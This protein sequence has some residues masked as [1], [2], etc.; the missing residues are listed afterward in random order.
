[1][2]KLQV[3]PVLAAAAIFL[4]LSPHFAR[5][6]DQWAMSQAN[7]AHT[8]YVPVTL[9]PNKFALRWKR[10]IDCGWRPVTV[11]G[12]RVF[13]TGQNLHALDA[14][15]GADV[16][17]AA[18]SDFIASYPG[19]ADGKV[20]IETANIA[21][22][23]AAHLLSYDAATGAPVFESG[24]GEIGGIDTPT[25]FKDN[26]YMDDL[27]SRTMCSFDRTYGVEDWDWSVAFSQEG[28]LLAVD[29]KWI[30]TYL[31][32]EPGTNPCHN[33]LYVQDRL[34]GSPVF[35]IAQSIPNDVGGGAD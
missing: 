17:S 6:S 35:E 33:T 2:P 31:D 24:A 28:G 19:Y 1:M 12:G 22:I 27:D 21:G 8:G 32:C 15:T 9:N 14:S 11:A 7:A 29:D 18:F 16:W 4:L 23:T 20:Y 5:S 34:T 26:I 30:Y 10:S 25:I 3:G 13:F